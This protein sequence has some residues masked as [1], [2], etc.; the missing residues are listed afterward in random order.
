MSKPRRL[1][2]IG[3]DAADWQVIEPLLEAGALPNLQRL[4][5]GG[6]MGNLATLYPIISP[7]LWNS[8]ATGK[9][10][11][12]H[13]IHGFTEVGEDGMAR[14]V[15]STSRRTKALWNILQQALG[16]RSHVVGWWA[17]HPAEP[18]DGIVVSDRLSRAREL[19]DGT[20]TVPPHTVHPAARAA[21]FAE[22]RMRPEEVTEELILPFIPRAAEIDQTTDQRLGTFA[23][24]FA[25]ACSIQS[26]ITAAMEAEPWDFAAVYFDAIDHFSHGF[27]PYHP[28]R[29]EHIA[30]RDFEL[31]RG[32][33]EGA[34][35][36]HDLMLARLLELA[37][38]ET[39]VVL[40]SDHGFKS[41]PTRPVGNPNDPAGPILWHREYGVLVLHGPGIKRD[42]RISGATLLDIV[43]TVLTALGLPVG[44]D[45]DGKVLVD[46]FVERPA[47]IEKIPSW[48][49]V[50]GRDGRHP[51]G[52][53][54]TSTREDAEE[55]M[56]QFA[57]LGY[58][59]DPTQDRARMG[60]SVRLENAF[61]LS[62]VLLSKA[63]FEQAV[64][65]LEPIVR[66][67]PWE[68]RFVHQLANAY[69]RA[70]R[71]RVADE[72]LGAAYP[73]A[74]GEPD[75]PM[76]AWMLRARAKL[77]LRETGTAGGYLRETMRRIV[78]HAPAWV[79]VGHLWLELPEL[80]A[81]EACFRRA[82]ELDPDSAQAWLGLSGV[83]LR[84]R[85]NLAAID[86][87]LEAV[88]L[89]HH[90][91]MAHF[92]LGLALARE[93]KVEEAIVAFRRVVEM[94][95]R[96]LNAHRC[97]AVL[98]R[99]RPD[100]R[101]LADVHRHELQR[102]SALRS[103]D[104]K[105]EAQRREAPWAAFEIPPYSARLAQ[106]ETARPTPKEAPAELSGRIF[107]LVSGLPRSGTS[108]MMQMLAAGGLPPQTDGE[109]RAD[110][111][112][113]E[114]YLEWEAIREIR[115]RPE[116]LDDPA[117]ERR[118]IKVVSPLLPS[119]PA[120]HRYRI[121]FM[122][123]PCEEIAQSQARMIA[124]RGTEGAS[125]DPAALAA[126]LRAHR[127]QTLEFLRRHAAA[128]DV[129]EVD[130]PALVADPAPWVGK[131]GAFLGEDLLPRP[132]EMVGAVRPELRRH[133]NA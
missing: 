122:L 41:G 82:L 117:L 98:Y 59:N 79:E 63:E 75:P 10:A 4:I 67:R 35:R 34:Y 106:E 52:F 108:L 48:D 46:A 72:L 100:E 105:A 22:L 8:I 40:C 132:A 18:L 81:A 77:G 61:N 123:R 86:S 69:L 37:G 65:V 94:Q 129:L 84:R 39:L 62:Q 26:A 124:R 120:R 99:M 47:R 24:I 44:A 29:A 73:V 83:Q 112:N 109:R 60:E 42:E 70:G 110:E 121:L 20:W 53:R 9:T 66:T 130:Y 78:R 128:F 51:P 56:K 119:L 127:E 91:P 80:S 11:D 131:I 6:V 102:Q 54:W 2:L 32:V 93:G 36:F 43:P 5:E 64:Q 55:L 57:A 88:R 17:S 92:N 58:I 85:E 49:A 33:I 116:L 21:E 16:W 71:F 96:A 101:F 104:R 45:M 25:D 15:T 19:P 28:P 27:M 3:W 7:M 31:Y 50:E 89:L 95:P 90:L 13:G 118:A 76:V 111:D 1:L 38:P 74:P 103:D 14:P 133:T 126:S 68:T 114:G 23:R 30:E 87:A 12:R 113:P 115:Q 97:L 107:T 125:A